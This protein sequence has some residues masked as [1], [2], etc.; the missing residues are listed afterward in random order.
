MVGNHAAEQ[1]GRN[2]ADK[3]CRRTETRH[4][5]SDIE[6]GTPTTGTTASRPSTALT[7]RKSIKASP[8]L[9]SIA[10]VFRIKAGDQFAP[11]H[12]IAAFPIQFPHRP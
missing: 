12:R 3:P 10:L 6:A 11:L 8:Q 2:T 4:A 9:S 5:D 7:G 1:I